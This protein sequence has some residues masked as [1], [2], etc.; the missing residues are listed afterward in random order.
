MDFMDLERQR[1]ITIQVGTCSAIN[2]VPVDSNYC[3][4]VHGSGRRSGVMVSWLDSGS[5]PYWA[6][7]VQALAGAL[8]GV[9]GEDTLL[10]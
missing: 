2:H 10:S 3:T 8:R 1:G 4:T 5:A 6:V 7:W 9:L